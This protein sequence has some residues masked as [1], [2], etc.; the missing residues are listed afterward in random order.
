MSR[1]ST[2]SPGALP[3]FSLLRI[4]IISLGENTIFFLLE[5]VDLVSTWGLFVGLIL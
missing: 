5:A 3:F 4:V 2:W 1:E